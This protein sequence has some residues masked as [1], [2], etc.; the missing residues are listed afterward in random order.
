LL[1]PGSALLRP[2][3]ERAFGDDQRFAVS[4]RVAVA[5]KHPDRSSVPSVRNAGL[6]Q[7]NRVAGL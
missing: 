1:Y 3:I 2:A 6:E 4:V 7:G 5:C